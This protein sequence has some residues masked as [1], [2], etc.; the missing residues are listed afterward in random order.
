MAPCLILINGYPGVGKN[1]IAKL[2]H[3]ALG[4]D[5]TFIHNHLLIDPVEAIYP[6]RTPAHY[7]LRK[8]FRDVAFDALIADSNPKLSIL[9]T[10]SLAANNDDIAV[11]YEHLRISRE[12]RLPVY[13]INL[14]CDDKEHKARMVSEERKNGGTSKCTD[15]A[16]LDAIKARSG[17]SL[18]TATDISKDVGSMVVEYRQQNTTGALPEESAQTALRWM[19]CRP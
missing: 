10:I 3:K 8:K 4:S 13:W 11:M 14:I 1:T 7:A 9:I 15:P 6:G 5:C 17:T 19:N 18:L 16:V 2:V 12:R